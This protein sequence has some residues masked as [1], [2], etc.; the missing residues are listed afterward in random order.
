MI[1]WVIRTGKEMKKEMKK[2]KTKIY[3][4]ILAK[5]LYLSKIQENNNFLTK[6]PSQSAI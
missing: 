3:T 5:A 2:Y 1:S 6:I 4:L